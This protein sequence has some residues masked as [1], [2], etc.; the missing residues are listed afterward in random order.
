MAGQTI[1]AD[2]IE[3]IIE[4]GADAAQMDADG[5]LQI[6]QPDGGVVIEFNPPVAGAPG[7]KR[8]KDFYINFAEDLP[9][10]GVVADELLELIDGDDNSRQQQLANYAK[11]LGLLGTELREPSSGAGDTS[12]ADGMSVV[13]NPL[14]LDACVKA[15]ANAQA[16]MLPADGPCKIEDYDTL[17]D[18]EV[19]GLADAFQRD[20]NY[21]F[22]V[23]AKEYAPSTSRMLLWDTIFRGSGFKKIYVSPTLRR[24]TSEAIPAKNFIVSDAESDLEVC[25]RITHV[26]TMRPSM[27][28]RLQLQGFYRNDVDL[29]PSTAPQKNAVDEKVASIQGVASGVNNRPENEPYT[30][31]ETQ[32]EL[33]LPEFAQPP[34]APKG[35]AEKGIALP[36]LVTIEKDSRTILS[37]RRDW[38]IGDENCTRK[39]MYV[40]YP[41]IPG[42][43]FY[44]TGMVNLL[45]NANAA[46]TAAWRLALDAGM[47]A[48]FPGGL[49]SKLGSRQNSSVFRPQPGEF[50]QVDSN[51]DD[52][53]KF[54]MALPYKD[55]TPGL[56]TLIDKI[57]EQSKGVAG[58]AE[59][60]V[61]EGVQN[62][63]VGTMLAHIEQATKVMAASHKGMH[64]AQS[65][66]IQ[67]IVDLFRDDPESFWRANKKNGKYWNEAMLFKALNTFSLVP[68]SDP[69]VPSHIHRMMKAV[70]LLQLLDLPGLKGK[71][72]ANG[73]LDRVLI[74]MNENPVGIV[75]PQNPNAPPP[76]PPLKDQAAMVAAKAKV[77]DA[78]N[79]KAQMVFS[80]AK[81]ASDT[82]Q[83]AIEQA[84]RER[85]EGMKIVQELVKQDSEGEREDR[86]LD[87]DERSMGLEVAGKA[88]DFETKKLDHENKRRDGDRED[89]RQGVEEHVALRGADRED[90]A[91]DREDLTAL[92]GVAQGE[93]KLGIEETKA[94]QPKATAKPK[95]PKSKK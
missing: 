15:W 12:A 23:V 16:E 67:M 87:L 32:C 63:P 11:G 33:N 77:M 79:D 83:S 27:L 65:R 95:K 90:R 40:K 45:G 1:V 81:E 34:F 5:D 9:N 70:A 31:Y 66:E 24:P 17:D 76:P 71:L 72:D 89:R 53:R 92:T 38:V 3:V 94:K 59:V 25:E 82:Q 91:A 14:L 42:P 74:A 80:A 2:D 39:Q 21:W 73:V 19:K 88:L 84:G 52:I 58:A 35:F 49:I 26:I 50:A 44:G 36:Y 55:V 78:E 10:A 41:Y 48:N 4:E 61:G 30:L 54:I 60:P 18:N 86:R 56:M 37:I 64:T 7:G 47:Y 93:R 85:I 28:K 6:A 29:A 57:T 13:T 75:I 62:V 46:L 51:G 22:T 43:G 69:N 8:L 68:K 20:L